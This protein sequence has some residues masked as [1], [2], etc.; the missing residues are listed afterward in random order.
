V[1][2]VVVVAALAQS[3]LTGMLEWEGGLRTTLV[4]ISF[5]RGVKW[6]RRGVV[7]LSVGSE[8]MGVEVESNQEHLQCTLRR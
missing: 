2:N 8:M 4:V 1:V 5:N 7:R 6:R 3:Q